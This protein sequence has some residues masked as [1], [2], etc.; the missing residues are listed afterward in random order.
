MHRWVTIKSILQSRISSTLIVLLLL[1]VALGVIGGS[2][3]AL[4]HTHELGIHAPEHHHAEKQPLPHH[5]KDVRD[6]SC[7]FACGAVIQL[8]SG[9]GAI[10]AR[11]KFYPSDADQ[12]NVWIVPPVLPYSR[13]TGPPRATPA[14]S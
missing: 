2:S 6:C 12:T 4:G 10:T 7:C 9:D 13:H 3:L 5:D 11:L 8:A 14:L 1:P